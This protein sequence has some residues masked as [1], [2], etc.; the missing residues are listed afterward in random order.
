M[1][2]S[3]RADSRSFGLF[4]THLY[5][6]LTLPIGLPDSA[7]HQMEVVEEAGS[8]S[9]TCKLIPGSCNDSRAIDIAD[10]YGVCTAVTARARELLE[11]TPNLAPVTCPQTSFS[12]PG[13]AMPRFVSDDAASLLKQVACSVIGEHIV[14]AQ[15]E[16]NRVPGPHT[17]G[18]SCVYVLQTP[19]GW[20]Y[21]GE[22]ED[23]P[24]RVEAHR[25]CDT[26]RD[27]RVLYVKVSTADGISAGGRS[28]ARSLE[29][30][31]IKRMAT[32]GYAMLSLHDGSR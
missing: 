21:V 14:V 2:E 18:V 24:S 12:T 10:R 1:L 22:T 25:H 23:L 20:Y 11:L 31:L 15:V 19:E 13:G 16:A 7:M 8:W 32:E 6:T 30:A 26:K 9:T 3:L 27:S 4:A 5:H 29:A 17:S 28:V